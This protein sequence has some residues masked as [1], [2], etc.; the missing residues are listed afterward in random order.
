MRSSLNNDTISRSI[1]RFGWGRRAAADKAA[2]DQDDESKML[3]RLDR[4]N[5]RQ[6]WN[7]RFGVEVQSPN[8][9]FRNS[10][11]THWDWSCQLAE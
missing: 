9:S 5:P 10:W 4:M 11:E 2:H 3:T 1:L 8:L 7:G 6:C